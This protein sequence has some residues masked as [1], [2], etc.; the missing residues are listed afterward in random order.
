[1]YANILEYNPLHSTAHVRIE[2]LRTGLPVLSGVEARLRPNLHKVRERPLVGVERDVDV[3]E[4]HQ[5]EVRAELEG[6]EVPAR[7]LLRRILADLVDGGIEV[8]LKVG[9]EEVPPRTYLGPFRRGSNRV[10]RRLE[11]H[12]VGGDALHATEDDVG[13]RTVDN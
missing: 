4:M 1:M 3:L 13:D 9:E 6:G 8:D 12:L 11:V 5:R 2:Y 10:T 7:R